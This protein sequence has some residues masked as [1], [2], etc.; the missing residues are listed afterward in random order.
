MVRILQV[1]THMNRGGLETML[2]NY[3]RHIDREQIQFDFL[4]HRPYDGDYGEEIR[5]LGGKIYHLP[6]LNP[7]SQSYHRAL[8]DF[9]AKHPEYNVVHVHQDCMSSVI[10]KAAKNHGM[11]VRIAHSHCSSQDKNW[12]YPIKLYFRGRIPKYATNLMACGDDAGKWMFGDHEFSVLCNA[13][14]TGLYR[15]NSST[16]A[17]QRK[18]W[19]ISDNT[20]LIGHVGRFSPQKN[21][22]RLIEIFGAVS[23]RTDAKLMLVGKGDLEEEIRAQVDQLGLSDK[24]IFTGLRSDVADLLQAM[25]VFVFPS[26]YEGVPVT[27][28]EAQAAG[29]PCIISDKVPIECKI[30]EYVKQIPLAEPDSVWADQAIRMSH[31]PRQDTYQDVLNSGYD[32]TQNASRLQTFYM[33]EWKDAASHDL[34]S[35]L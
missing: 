28:I 22:T 35:K 12:K 4:T 31:L 11:K 8:N 23:K 25:D 29:L 17:F 13:I 3:Y 15:Y 9:F 34:H 14:D 24:V 32:I 27:M 20:L 5:N 10:L 7:F 33:E 30:T 6:V 18:I 1:V 21:H 2:M 19:G 16:R 26:N